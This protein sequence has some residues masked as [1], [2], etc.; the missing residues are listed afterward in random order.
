[1]TAGL[2]FRRAGPADAA[3]IRSITRAAYAKWIAVIGREPLPMTFDYDLAVLTHQI[4][5]AVLGSDIAG[6]IELVEMP[7][8]VL[9]ENLAV[10]P[11]FQGKGIGASLLQKGEHIAAAGH[12][13]T[14]R[15]YTNS[16]FTQNIR[17]YTSK[18]YAVTSEEPFKGGRITHMAKHLPRNIKVSKSEV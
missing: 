14:I 16:M 17:F 10:S 12:R 1:M 3:I 2:E 9:I 15:L 7:D 5:L 4:Q 6:L 13:Q 18:G 8:Y 11:G